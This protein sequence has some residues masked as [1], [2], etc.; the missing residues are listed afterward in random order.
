MTWALKKLQKKTF[1][2]ANK[3]GRYLAQQLKKK[4]EKRLINRVTDDQKEIT[5]EKE[6]KA[7]FLKY[8]SNLYKEEQTDSEKLEEYMQKSQMRKITETEREEL[9]KIITEEEIAAAIGAI[10][11]GKAPGTDGFS[12]KFYK[13]FKK[14]LV[15]KFQ[16]VAN[17]LLE[18]EA[19]PKTV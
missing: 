18:E 1:E 15:P 6:I 7:R 10:K 11:M 5:E 9:N 4:K 13:K 17:N 16:K 8:Y 14:I 2:G 19:P 3:P 12:L